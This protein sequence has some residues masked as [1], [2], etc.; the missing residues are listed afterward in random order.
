V[1]ETVESKRL[2]SRP[3][4]F[5]GLNGFQSLINMELLNSG[6]Q[7]EVDWDKCRC[8]CH[9]LEQANIKA[10]WILLTVKTWLKPFPLVRKCF[11]AFSIWVTIDIQTYFIYIF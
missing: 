2:A 8:S 1:V 11:G 10:C 3:I 6:M 5:V 7:I 9:L 4:E